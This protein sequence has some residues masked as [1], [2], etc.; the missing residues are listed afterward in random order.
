[1]RSFLMIAGAVT[2]IGIG[3]A[4]LAAPPPPKTPPAASVDQLRLQLAADE[5]QIAKL[6]TL[7]GAVV[8]G[9]RKCQAQRNAA[10]DVALDDAMNSQ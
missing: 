7:N 3:S 6:Q 8:R 9:L 2:V 10:Q 4:V 5:Q 1:M